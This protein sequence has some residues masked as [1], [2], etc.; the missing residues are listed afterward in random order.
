MK[1]LDGLD[2][3]SHWKLEVWL[4]ETFGY[5]LLTFRNN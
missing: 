3:H 1:K 2:Q 5:S 4:A